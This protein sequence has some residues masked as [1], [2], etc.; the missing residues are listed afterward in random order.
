MPPMDS[1]GAL[2]VRGGKG[3]SAAGLYLLASRRVNLL[4]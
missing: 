2:I 3:T 4:L 1:K